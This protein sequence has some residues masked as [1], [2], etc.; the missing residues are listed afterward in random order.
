MVW[1]DPRDSYSVSATG[2]TAYVG[3][4]I[5]SVDFDLVDSIRAYG[6]EEAE[7]R[8]RSLRVVDGRE[9]DLSKL[10]ERFPAFPEPVVAERMH[11]D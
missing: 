11:A 7:Y 4:L 3:T 5:V 2:G 1:S 10:R 8:I 9:R 6:K